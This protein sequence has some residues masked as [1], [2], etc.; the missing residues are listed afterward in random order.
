MSYLA[1]VSGTLAMESFHVQG[2][3]QTELLTEFVIWLYLCVC[4]C[5][6]QMQASNTFIDDVFVFVIT[7]PTSQRIAVFRDDLVFLVYLYQRW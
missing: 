5:V 6:C 2:N 3:T 7:M 1:E 4:V